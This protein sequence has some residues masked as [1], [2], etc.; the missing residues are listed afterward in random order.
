[1]RRIQCN[2]PVK[3]IGKPGSDPPP[4]RGAPVVPDNRE[5]SAPDALYE[6]DDVGREQVKVVCR[7]LTGSL[8]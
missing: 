6:A 5:F 2:E 3:S 4:D 1:M 7:D 8:A